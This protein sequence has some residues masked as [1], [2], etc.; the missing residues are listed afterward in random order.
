MNFMCSINTFNIPCKPNMSMNW[1]WRHDPNISLISFSCHWIGL[2][3]WTKCR[4]IIIF[5]FKSI[6]CGMDLIDNG[7]LNK[8]TFVAIKIWSVFKKIGRFVQFDGSIVGL[9]GSMSV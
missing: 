3:T 1:V 5:D 4:L 6:G 9:N 2:M 8:Q 7:P